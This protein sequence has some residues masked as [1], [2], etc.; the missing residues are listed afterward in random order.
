MVST[1]LLLCV[2]PEGAITGGLAP[3]HVGRGRGRRA[4]SWPRAGQ[5][6]NDLREKIDR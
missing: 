4:G 2:A 6:H 1:E 5:P 3:C